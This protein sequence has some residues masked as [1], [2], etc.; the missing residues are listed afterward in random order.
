MQSRFFENM[1]AEL[2]ELMGEYSELNLRRCLT[3]SAMLSSDV[4]AGYDPAYA[5][6]FE[7]KNSAFLEMEWYS[8]KFTGSRG[9]SGSNDANAGIC[10]AYQRHYGQPDVVFQTAELG[11]VDV[12]GGGTIAYIMALYG[13]NVIDCGVAVLNM[14]APWKP[15]ARP[16]Y[17]E[18]MRGYVAFLEKPAFNI[19]RPRWN[20]E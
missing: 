3:N 15:P 17:K 5:S 8:I 14:H 4:S 12:G 20:A 1:T 9:K 16:M 10:G 13:M 7:K 2:M 6:C 19:Q 11:K 18:T